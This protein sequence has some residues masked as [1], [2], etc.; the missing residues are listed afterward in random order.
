[1]PG[2]EHRVQP[3][4]GGDRDGL[5]PADG[6]PDGVDARS[7]AGDEV[8]RG[9]AHARGLGQRAD[10]AHGLAEGGGIERDDPRGR[11]QL[12]GDPAHVS[13]GHRA[14]RAQ[15]LRHDQ[16]GLELGQQVLV[17]HVDRLA[18][19]RA[20]AHRGVDLGGAQA[21]RQ[22]VAG[23]LRQALDRGRVVALVRD[24]DHVVAEAQREEQLG[25]VRDQADDAHRDARG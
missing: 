4:Q 15:I 7:L 18:A 24:A 6:L 22:H 13:R 19:L 16:V 12:G 5:G 25:G 1:V 11:G 8:Q 14:H 3:L 17:Q 23:D 21:R 10:V 20:L 9:V 2:H